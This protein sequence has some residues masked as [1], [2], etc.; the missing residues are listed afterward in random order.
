MFVY[1][2][3]HVYPCGMWQDNGGWSSSPTHYLGKLRNKKMTKTFL[4]SRVEWNDPENP[5]RFGYPSKDYKSL[6][7]SQRRLLV[8]QELERSS[9][10]SARDTTL[11]RRS[12]DKDSRQVK[13]IAAVVSSNSCSTPERVWI[14]RAK[15]ISQS[16]THSVLQTLCLIFFFFTFFFVVVFVIPLQDL[17]SDRIV[18]T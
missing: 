2:R 1:M 12:H 15:E 4:V 17:C 7:A 11:D 5:G 9:S 14:N 6:V 13:N 16:S 18:R 10:E 8:P 3:L